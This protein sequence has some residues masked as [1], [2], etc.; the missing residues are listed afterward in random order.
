MEVIPQPHGREKM[1]VFESNY[2][3]FFINLPEFYF[4]V[5]FKIGFTEC[6]PADH[7]FITAINIRFTIHLGSRY[8]NGYTAWQ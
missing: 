5:G 7:V 8:S 3:K 4:T 2:N 1:I 6:H